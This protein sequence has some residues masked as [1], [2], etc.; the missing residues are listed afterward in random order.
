MAKRRATLSDLLNDLTFRI[1]YDKYKSLAMNRFKWNGL[2]ALGI[3]ERHVERELFSNGICGFYDDPDYNYLA[4]K[5]TPVG[6]MNVYGDALRYTLTGHGYRKNVRRNDLVIIENNINRL[7]T[8][9][10]IMF[11]AN[12]IT[13]AERTMDVNVKANKTPVVFTCDDKD[14]L[15][16]M[17]LFETVDGNAPAV[18]CDKS[19]NPDAIQVFDTKVKFLC[20]DLMDYKKSVENELLTF[21]GINNT[22]VEKRERLI[23][24]EANSNNDLIDSFVALQ[25]EAR[26]RACEEINK[27]YGLNVSVELRQLSVERGVENV[28]NV[29]R[30]PA[31]V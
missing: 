15:S 28:E 4:L 8:E 18:Y 19:M 10:F 3:N 27:K 6:D 22:P 25:L 14:K 12:K 20:A 24:D 23:T 26:E 9:P 30:D 5:C 7:A 29:E 11:Y 16:F 17:R 31:T 2:D 21:L 13:E 1:T